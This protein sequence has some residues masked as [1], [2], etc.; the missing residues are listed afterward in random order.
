[1][2]PDRARKIAQETMQDRI[3]LTVEGMPSCLATNEDLVWFARH[4]RYREAFAQFDDRHI[5]HYSPTRKATAAKKRRPI[6]LGGGC[7]P[8][9]NPPSRPGR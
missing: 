8:P 3:T 9:S 5:H 4:R 1:M 6:G 2:K 7:A